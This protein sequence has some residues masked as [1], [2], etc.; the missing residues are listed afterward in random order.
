MTEHPNGDTASGPPAGRREQRTTLRFHARGRVAGHLIGSNQP[1]FVLNVSLG[2][3]AA[4]ASEAIA[5]GSH[6]VRLTTPD[7]TATLLEA[8]RVYCRQSDQPLSSRRFTA[9]FEF[10]RPPVYTDLAIKSILEQVTELRL[11]K[12]AAYSKLKADPT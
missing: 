2:G 8:R 9:G 7:Q 5:A 3:F 6:I 4:E 12:P 10:I 11:A 1:V